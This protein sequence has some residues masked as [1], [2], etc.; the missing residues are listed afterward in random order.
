L[1]QGGEHVVCTDAFLG[2]SLGEGTIATAAIV[3]MKALKDTDGGGLRE[4]DGAESGLGSG[5]GG[6]PDELRLGGIG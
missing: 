2:A 5:H 3:Q 4:S 6:P 1:G